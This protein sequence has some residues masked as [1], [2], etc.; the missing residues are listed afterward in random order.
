MTFYEDLTKALAEALEGTLSEDQ[1]DYIASTERLQIEGIELG[2]VTRLMDG[3]FLVVWTYMSFLAFNW[4]S[5][6]DFE[7]PSHIDTEPVN[8]DTLPLRVRRLI[9]RKVAEIWPDVRH[10]IGESTSW[11]ITNPNW[12]AM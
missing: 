9:R 4:G 7:V 8:T 12:N 1:R 2:Y 11:P 5:Q 3:N 10:R 6:L